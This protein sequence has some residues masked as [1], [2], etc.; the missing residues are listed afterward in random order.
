[1]KWLQ[2]NTALS[3]QQENRLKQMGAT[4]RNASRY[5]DRL[6]MNEEKER[7]A[8]SIVGK[9]SIEQLSDL[10]SFYHMMGQIC[11]EALEKKLQGLVNDLAL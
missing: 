6:K 2:A 5:I 11:S 3:L 9:M 7:F 4:V 8:R 10:L 1:M